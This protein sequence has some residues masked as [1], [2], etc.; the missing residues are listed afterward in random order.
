LNRVPDRTLSWYEQFFPSDS[1]SYA[2]VG[3]VTPYYLYCGERQLEF[4]RQKIP[5]ARR[6]IVI[7]RNPVERVYSSYWFKR[8]VANIDE[9]FREYV[10]Q[11]EGV[12][13]QSEYVPHVRRWLSHF[14]SE[15]FLFLILEEDVSEPQRAKQKISDFLGVQ[16]SGFPDE[17]GTQKKNDRWVPVLGDLYAWATN[18]A[19]RLRRRDLD[20]VVRLAEKAGAKKVFGRRTVDDE[21]MDDDVR[22]ALNA[23]L[24][25]QVPELEKLIGRDL[26]VWQK[27][28][29]N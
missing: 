6:F 27:T 22:A 16:A 24:L 14:D 3:E 28:E 12:L 1:G 4:L 8:R 20:W 15:N 10:D 5:S 23:R 2:A 18:F 11:N 25:D 29:E 17:A 19:D 13:E 7:L 26:S 21:G 9:S